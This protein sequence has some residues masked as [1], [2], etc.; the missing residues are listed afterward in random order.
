MSLNVAD[1]R[2]QFPILSREVNGHPLVYLDNAATTQ[3][4][5]AVIDAL[6]DYYT[7]CNSNVHRGAH[8]LSDEATRR[9]EAARQTVAKYINAN[10]NE[11][12]IW[13]SGT[14]EGINLV[15][16]GVAQ[17]L[18]AGDEVM[19]TEMEHHADLVTWQQAC[20]RSGATLK[21]VPIHDN[22]EL[23]VDAFH[24]LLSDN[25]A[26]VAM[27]HVSN[28]LGTVNPIKELTAAAKSKGAL[29]LIDGA[30][31]V[32]H[33]AIDVQDI[34]CDFYVFSGH[35]V[36]GPTGIG[37]LWG[38]FDVLNDW[39]VWLVG[40]EMI[41][42]VSYQDA[43]WGELPNRLEAGTPNI[44]GVIGLAAAIDW[45]QQ[46]DAEEIRAHEQAL[47]A[48]ATELAKQTE[49]LRIIGDAPN[50]IGVLSFVLEGAHPADIGFLLD[51]QGIAIRTGDHCAQPLMKRL[52]VPGTAR[53]SFTIY[54]T[55]DEVD[56]LFAGIN[57]A[58]MMLA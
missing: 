50:K 40:G 39:P 35:K 53:A 27:P 1:I 2:K 43:T 47:L 14:T 36:F 56:Q 54:N 49:G 19:V 52:N 12:V 4:P 5:Q 15:A 18:K 51:K 25:T 34:G 9:Y 38:R 8:Y 3:K 32:A 41:A 20:K 29:V 57:K 30:Q 13:T 42:T 10:R 7:Q 26:F 46:Y 33:G 6:V 44:A 23:N 22:G 21:V 55:L 11:E 24:E 31:G 16:N 17:R 58:R 48:R 28:A 45:I 37:V